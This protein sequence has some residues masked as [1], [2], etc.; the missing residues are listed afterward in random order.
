[1]AWRGSPASLTSVS[2][3][4]AP[5]THYAGLKGTERRSIDEILADESLKNDNRHVQVGL[6]SHEFA[7][8]TCMLLLGDFWVQRTI[9]DILGK[10]KKLWHDLRCI[11]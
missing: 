5:V 9:L 6:C 4:P 10:S 11:V 7:L 1:M 2:Y 3:H 8:L